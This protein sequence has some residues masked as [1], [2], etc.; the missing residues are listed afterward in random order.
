MFIYTDLA[1]DLL[2]C[3][4]ENTK[5]RI[6]F[7]CTQNFLR[8]PTAERVFS[9]HVHLDV[10]SAGT[11]EKATIVLTSE[12]LKWADIVFVMEKRHQNTIRKKFN[13]IFSTKRI[14]CL[15]IRDEYD[16]MDQKLIYILKEKV[17]PFLKR[18]L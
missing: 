14:I 16:F 12:L 17:T 6:L 18:T 7:V 1:N 3:R 8:S 15:S 2:S 11:D 4:D 9:E 10:K 5:T 13:D